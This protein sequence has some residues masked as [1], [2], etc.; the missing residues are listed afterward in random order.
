MA[1]QSVPDALLSALTSRDFER[2][3]ACLAPSAQARLF[4]PRGPEMQSG[5]DAV[6]RRFEGW[7]APAAAFEVLDS[8]CEPIGDRH[9]I[10]WRFR[11]SRDGKAVEVIEQ[12]AF[13]D[14]TAEGITRIDMLCSG[15]LPVTPQASPAVFD[16]QS[17]GCADGLAQEFRRRL[18]ELTVGE[19]LTVI[20]GDP[21][22]KEDL[23][24]LVRMLGQSITACE[25]QSDDRMAITVEKRK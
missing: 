1:E 2:F 5:R 17:M 21:A 24:S 3:A 23:P 4:L 19:L 15:F 20:V 25:T 18:A 10:T 9:R 14:V 12:L 16:A 7:F 13:V 11:V 22:A 6:A 8:S